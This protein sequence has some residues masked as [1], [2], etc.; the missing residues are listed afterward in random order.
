MVKSLLWYC[1]LF[2]SHPMGPRAGPSGHGCDTTTP[3][4]SGRSDTA[5]DEVTAGLKCFIFPAGTQN[6]H[7]HLPLIH[8]SP[9]HTPEWFEARGAL[10]AETRQRLEEVLPVRDEEAK[11][12]RGYYMNSILGMYRHAGTSQPSVAHPT[13]HRGMPSSRQKGVVLAPM[14]EFAHIGN[15]SR[16]A[17]VIKQLF[18]DVLILHS[19]VELVLDEMGILDALM[20]LGTLLY[21]GCNEHNA[22]SWHRYQLPW[23]S[24]GGQSPNSHPPWTVHLFTLWRQKRAEAAGNKR[25]VEAAKHN[26]GQNYE[27]LGLHLCKSPLPARI[28]VPTLN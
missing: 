7:V 10:M 4:P 1:H 22:D 21:D 2:F 26:R 14:H 13:H 28:H 16:S 6:T 17:V 23:D 18:H 15:W 12:M 9:H 11:A 25:R 27:Q 24:S 5:V 3:G 19:D 20:F 8:P